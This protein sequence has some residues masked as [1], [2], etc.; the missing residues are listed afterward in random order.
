MEETLS[1]IPLTME[2]YSTVATLYPPNEQDTTNS[3]TQTVDMVSINSSQENIMIEAAETENGDIKS[4]QESPDRRSKNF[5][6]SS[7]VTRNSTGEVM[8]SR[9]VIPKVLHEQGRRLIR[10]STIDRSS[11]IEKLTT[12]LSTE[13]SDFPLTLTSTHSQAVRPETLRSEGRV[14]IQNNPFPDATTYIRK[15]DEFWE[16]QNHLAMLPKD[17]KSEQPVFLA[18]FVPQIRAKI[19][20]IYVRNCNKNGEEQFL[21]KI[22]TASGKSEFHIKKS[23]FLDLLKVL[24]HDYPQ[25]RLTSDL[26]NAANLFSSYLSKINE[27]AIHTLP[28]LSFYIDSGWIK[29]R[30]GSW[31]YVNGSDKDC[32]SKR[33]LVDITKWKSKDIFE[34]GAAV[35][36]IAES[37]IALP[38]YL[39]M[40]AGPMAELLDEVDLP[41][42]YI[43]N[44]VGGS[45][46]MKTS[47]AK[48]LYCLFD[49]KEFINFTA[50][51]A[52][53]ELSAERSWDAILFIDNQASSKNSE[54]KKK[55]HVFIKEF[56]DSI[57]RTIVIGKEL[58]QV[59]F[60]C[61]VVMTAE[62]SADFLQ[63]SS[64]LRLVEVDLLGY[65]FDEET[66]KKL[67]DENK[68]ADRE[69]HPRNLEIYIS[70]FIHFLEDNH[71]SLIDEFLQIYSQT[72][73]DNEFKKDIQAPRLR[74]VYAIFVCIAKTV[75]KFAVA[76]GFMSQDDADKTFKEE[77][78]PIIKSLIVSNDEKCKAA[79]PVRKF[80]EAVAHGVEYREIPIADSRDEFKSEPNQ[81]YG[82]WENDTFLFLNPSKVAKFNQSS[83]STESI[84]NLLKENELSEGYPQK[85]HKDKPLKVIQLQDG[86]HAIKSKVLCLNW[87]AVKNFLN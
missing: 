9:A 49:Q 29:T 45:G 38:L 25:L 7:E 55:L 46:K 62:N 56:C 41:I 26:R 22:R 76:S 79:E 81:F 67:Q 86:D 36:K 69:G 68:Q 10:A 33:K 73:S 87:Q 78:E 57:G 2:T 63:H 80:L 71:N 64:Q 42:Q 4:I 40:H 66:L 5:D 65:K 1:S 14:L 47:V 51:E 85:N 27:S 12:N 28:K 23:R 43:F 24:H 59:Q 35:L 13:D 20:S 37:E 48:L 72:M 39:Q 34:L 75:L 6:T 16:G 15:I 31:R 84:W 21:I 11:D 18:N 70:A 54:E 50:S 44:I 53:M 30:S 77:W 61:A 74:K 83:S 32:L 8:K 3:E 82:F 17:G 60:R 52:A 19:D 58:R